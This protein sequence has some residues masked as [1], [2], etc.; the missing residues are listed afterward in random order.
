VIVADC[1]D[2]AVARQLGF[3]PSH[4]VGHALEL[5][6]G[7]MGE[8]ASVGLMLGPPYAALRPKSAGG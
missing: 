5:A 3:I 4:G 6:S 1:R 7:S 2:A 8:D